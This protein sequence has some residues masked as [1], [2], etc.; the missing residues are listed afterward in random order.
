MLQ[1]LKNHIDEHGKVVDMQFKKIIYI[2]PMKALAQE[3]VAKFSERLAPLKLV[4]KEYT[5][6]GLPFLSFNLLLVRY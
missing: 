4:V 5:G 6:S 2:A 1:L 3:V